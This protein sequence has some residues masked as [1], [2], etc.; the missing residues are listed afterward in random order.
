M[1]ESGIHGDD[2]GDLGGTCTTDS[3]IGNTANDSQRP[4]LLL[5]LLLLWSTK[6]LHWGF[7]GNIH[8]F[9]RTIKSRRTAKNN[10]KLNKLEG[11]IKVESFKSQRNDS[12]HT[13][14]HESNRKKQI[15]D[16]FD[17]NHEVIKIILS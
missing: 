15:G 2:G 17:D 1:A 13:S 3:G 7:V 12:N 10:I 16:F 8:D 4:L 11:K 5:L 6:D 9:R 14:A